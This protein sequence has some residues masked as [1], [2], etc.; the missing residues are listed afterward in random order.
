M[1]EDA[2]DFKSA[3]RV[4]D[5]SDAAASVRAWEGYLAAHPSGRFVPEV[6]YARAVSL[7]RAGR[8][9]EARAAPTPFASAPAGSYRQADASRLLRTLP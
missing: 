7:L 3:Y 8:N 6:R 4:H 1:A 9:A 5:A 2:R